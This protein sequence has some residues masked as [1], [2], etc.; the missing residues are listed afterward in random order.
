MAGGARQYSIKATD[1][2]GSPPPNE[3]NVLN[4]ENT[5]VYV[6]I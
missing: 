6:V 2:S 3:A 4:K 1:I 5:G